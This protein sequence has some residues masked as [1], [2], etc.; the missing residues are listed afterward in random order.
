MPKRLTLPRRP[1]KAPPMIVCGCGLT[2]PVIECVAVSLFPGD[3]PEWIC[4][5]CQAN[6]ER[7]RK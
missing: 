4:E 3:K 2:V 7:K 5:D 1:A 6:L